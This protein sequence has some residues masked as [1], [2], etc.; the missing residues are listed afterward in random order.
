MIDEF[1]KKDDDSYLFALFYY[2]RKTFETSR[3]FQLFLSRS[4]K[5]DNGVVFFLLV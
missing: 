2:S 4:Q 5:Y 3:G 1:G